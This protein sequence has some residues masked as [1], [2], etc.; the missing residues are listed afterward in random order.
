MERSEQR[1]GMFIH[2]QSTVVSQPW[3]AAKK[4]VFQQSFNENAAR[5]PSKYDSE[6]KPQI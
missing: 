6:P 3:Y 4:Q 2:R 1:Q 5:S